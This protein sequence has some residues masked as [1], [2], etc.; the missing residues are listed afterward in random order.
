MID[1]GKR[2]IL[3]IGVNVVDY[4]GAVARVISCAHAKERC[5]VSALAVHGVMCGA[6]DSAQKY[7]LNQLDIITPDG[8][9]V[10]W[11]LRLLHGE[12]LEDRVYGPN[13]TLKICEQAEQEGLTI[14][15]FGSRLEVLEKLSANLKQ[16]FPKLNIAGF[17]PS[18]F[19][20]GNRDDSEKLVRKIKASGADIIFVG[21][22]C[23]R[24]EIFAFENADRF[25]L[26]IVAVGAAF[27]FHAGMVAQAPTCM[28]DFGLE[29]LYRLSRE[30]G[31]LWRRYLFL[32]PA[33]CLLLVAQMLKLEKYI[34]PSA[35][36]P[37][38]EMNYL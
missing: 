18:A 5:T 16:R 32:N 1:S 33:Y 20:T 14:F 23:P 11:A 24:Q 7:R 3:G 26:P 8:Q 38:N 35:K 17:E 10:R 15:L 31:R 37:D 28:Q 4:D 27:D 30:P 22:G 2:S 19:R 9:P 13:L 12:T 34:T 6:L 21:L 29:W 25:S 36:R